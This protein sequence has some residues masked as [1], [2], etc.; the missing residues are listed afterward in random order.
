MSFVNLHIGQ[1]G[2]QATPTLA[3]VLG[4]S[5]LLRSGVFDEIWLLKS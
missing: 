2:N 4:G 5:D 3:S 1:I